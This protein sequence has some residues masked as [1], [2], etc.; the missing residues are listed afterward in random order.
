MTTHRVTL[1]A[2]Y[3]ELLNGASV[4]VELPDQ[5]RVSDLEVAL[6]RIPG[7]DLLPATLMI[8]VNLRHSG[9][10]TPIAPGDEVALLPPLAGG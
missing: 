2:R 7:G 8:A 10:D 9:P 6:R 5:A 3:A 4:E 1:F